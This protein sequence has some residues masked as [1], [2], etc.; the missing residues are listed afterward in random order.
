MFIKHR[1]VAHRSPWHV[2]IWGIMASPVDLRKVG[3]DWL[4]HHACN[5]KYPGD[6][7][8][9][10]SNATAYE[11]TAALPSSYQMVPLIPPAQ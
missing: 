3:E 5:N 10:K 8:G 4:D 11:T 1:R 9:N 2:R 6:H 7:F